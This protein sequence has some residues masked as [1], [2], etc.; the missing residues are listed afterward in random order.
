MR[1]G[2][3]LGVLASTALSF[4]PDHKR[5]ALQPSTEAL[6]VIT[7]NIPDHPL[8]TPTPL[9]VFLPS[10]FSGYLFYVGPCVRVLSENLIHK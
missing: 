1:G 10:T 7:L 2:S 8:V 9:P 6:T 5:L 4:P 3:G